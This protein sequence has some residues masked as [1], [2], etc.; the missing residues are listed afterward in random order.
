MPAGLLPVIVLCRWKIWT[1]VRRISTLPVRVTTLDG[2]LLYDPDRAEVS[3]VD[4]PYVAMRTPM[5]SRDVLVWYHV[6]DR[7]RGI[8][9]AVSSATTP[10]LVTHS[11][12]RTDSTAIAEGAT[13]DSVWAAVDMVTPAGTPAPVKALW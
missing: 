8:M 2:A 12:L 3:Q 10:T 11:W 7:L 6:D 9:P 1:A 5:S 13:G 4:G